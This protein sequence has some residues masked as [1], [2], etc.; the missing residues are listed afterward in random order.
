[1]KITFR[2]THN[3]FSPATRLLDAEKAVSIA[4]VARNQQEHFV[5][6][7][8]K[9]VGQQKVPAQVL[10]AGEGLGTAK[11]L[12]AEER[13]QLAASGRGERPNECGVRRVPGGGIEKEDEAHAVG[14]GVAIRHRPF[15]PVP[16]LFPL[17]SLFLRGERTE[18]PVAL[19]RK[20]RLEGIGPVG[21][22]E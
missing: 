14:D 6:V 19:V 22:Q 10:G 15:R 20:E 16:P 9:E 1:M 13:R 3:T 11:G 17:T 5:K 7:V 12:A 8:P 21:Q 2:H 18:Q 4:V